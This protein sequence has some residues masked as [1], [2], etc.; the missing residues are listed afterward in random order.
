LSKIQV[1]VVVVDQNSLKQKKINWTAFEH[2]LWR[3]MQKLRELSLG[4]S[5]GYIPENSHFLLALSGGVDSVAL[6]KALLTI[7]QAAK[8]KI[9]A[10]YVHHGVSPDPNVNFYRNKCENFCRQ[11]CLDHNIE[12]E[13]S[14][15]PKEILKSEES[16]RDFRYAQ[17]FDYQK[18]IG[19]EILVTAH[20]RDDL[21]ETRLL[22]LIRGTGPNGIASMKTWQSLNL[23][24]NQ[25]KYYKNPQMGFVDKKELKTVPVTHYLWRPLLKTSKQELLL[26]LKERRVDYIDDPSNSSSDYLRN[27]LRNE[28]LPQLEQKATGS[29]NSLA[30]SLEILAENLEN[31]Q[32][33]DRE[34]LLIQTIKNQTNAAV[35]GSDKDLFFVNRL[36]LLALG[37]VEKKQCIVKLL[38]RANINNISHGQINEILKQ[39]DNPQKVHRFKIGNCVWVVDAER[40]FVE[41]K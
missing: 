3:E 41:T 38:K 1:E 24:E 10:M 18:K 7:Q 34:D 14:E 6:L 9:S 16:F 5:L 4:N 21:L 19:A 12:F 23:N 28:W 8:I 17:L 22:R 32:S 29:V 30:R 36:D 33:Q 37:L 25:L 27:W 13:L 40:V 2:F 11:F 15:K 31:Y 20:H 39:L 26:Y 35:A